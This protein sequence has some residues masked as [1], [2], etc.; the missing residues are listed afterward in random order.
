MQ[1]EKKLNKDQR[2]NRPPILYHGVVKAYVGGDHVGWDQ[3]AE[4]VIFCK[5]HRQH[6][7]LVKR[8]LLEKYQM[9]TIY[10][11]NST[12]ALAPAQCVLYSSCQSLRYFET[13]SCL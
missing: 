5:I 4:C 1:D 6:H 3:L 2:P 8:L 12:L 7:F 9:L 10:I 11:Y 13:S